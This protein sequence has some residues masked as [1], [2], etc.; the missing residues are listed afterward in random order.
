MRPAGLQNAAAAAV[1]NCRWRWGSCRR[2]KPAPDWLGLA[3]LG[4][5]F[6]DAGAC[7]VFIQP[8]GVAGREATGGGGHRANGSRYTAWRLF[9]CCL[10]PGLPDARMWLGGG[11]DWRS[12]PPQRL[13][14]PGVLGKAI[15]A[16]LKLFPENAGGE[17]IWRGSQ[18][19]PQSCDTTLPYYLSRATFSG[20]APPR[21]TRGRAPL[22]FC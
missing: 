15:Q 19:P 10:P 21:P 7:A 17:R 1:A 22:E 9:F 4:V 14:A 13:W 12:L 2:S 18:N 6:T 16:V 20:R 5:V 11:G 8:A 3:V